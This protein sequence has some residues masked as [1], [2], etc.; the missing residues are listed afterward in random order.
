MGGGFILE[1]RLISVRR[2]RSLKSGQGGAANAH[3]GF[4]LYGISRNGTD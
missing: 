1:I 3:P 2:S 4:G